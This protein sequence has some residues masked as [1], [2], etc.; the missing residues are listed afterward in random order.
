M[1]VILQN[2][3]LVPNTN[4]KED[5]EKTLVE[6]VGANLLFK[7][8]NS[9]LAAYKQ[10]KEKLLVQQQLLNEDQKTEIK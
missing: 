3:Y 4:N 5:N 9:V 2:R 8:V 1:N 10:A 7:S 6:R